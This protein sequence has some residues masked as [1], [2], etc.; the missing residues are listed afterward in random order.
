[1]ELGEAAAEPF[2]ELHR[3]EQEGA[4]AHQAVRQKPPSERVDV[5][6][7]GILGVNEEVLVMAKN[8]GSHDA[9]DCE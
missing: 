6:P 7:F 3:A 1:M 9:N 2:R 5:R 4:G 8:V